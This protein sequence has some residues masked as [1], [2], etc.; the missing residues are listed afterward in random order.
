MADNQE[1]P[2]AR[3]GQQPRIYT[4]SPPWV[5]PPSWEVLHLSLAD[6]RQE[7]QQGHAAVGGDQVAVQ[8]DF[9]QDVQRLRDETSRQERNNIARVIKSG[10]SR[11]ST[12]LEPLYGVNGELVLDFPA[13]FGD[14]KALDDATINPPLVALG[15]NTDGTLSTRK[16]HF[17]KYIGLVYEA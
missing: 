12:A 5:L 17:Y 10:A 6:L 3:N 16:A 2:E 8:A 4:F 7:L 11:N 13:T 1:Q 15:L 14:A 9:L